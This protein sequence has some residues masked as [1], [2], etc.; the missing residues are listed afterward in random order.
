MRTRPSRHSSRRIGAAASLAAL[1]VLGGC[2]DGDSE[3]TD[4]DPPEQATTST[5]DSGGADEASNEVPALCTLLSA[6][7]FESVAGAPSAGE[8]VATPATGAARGMCTWSAEAGFPM[9]MI[10]AY[11]ASDRE[12]TLEMVDAEPVDGLEAEADWA[13]E[14][15]VLM[16][17]EIVLANL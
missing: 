3:T 1:L 12:A 13:A 16:V 8:P 14:T 9:V 5:Q 4:S 2:G 15:G 10:G 17:V 11:N 7:E 6:D